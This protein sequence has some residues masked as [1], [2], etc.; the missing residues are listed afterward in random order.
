[1]RRERSKLSSVEALEIALSLMQKRQ[2]D[3]NRITRRFYSAMHVRS[4]APR[5]HGCRS[6]AHAVCAMRYYIPTF[7]RAPR[8][9]SA[10]CTQT[11]P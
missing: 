11:R 10:G 9:A 1:M 7:E 8:C 4:D 3:T 6:R 5:A 2:K